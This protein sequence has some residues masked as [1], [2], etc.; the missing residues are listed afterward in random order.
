MISS[1]QFSADESVKEGGQELVMNY[2]EWFWE[3]R[4]LPGKSR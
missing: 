3:E 1:I 4:G 2:G